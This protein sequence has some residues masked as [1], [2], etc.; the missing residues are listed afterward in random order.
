MTTPHDPASSV[1]SRNKVDAI[2]D[3]LL[4]QRGLAPFQLRALW[5]VIA[6]ALVTCALM[7]VAAEQWPAIPAFLPAYHTFTIVTYSV[8]AYLLYGYFRQTGAG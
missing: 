1:P 8:A 6:I 5:T 3:A 7:P 2:T 4:A